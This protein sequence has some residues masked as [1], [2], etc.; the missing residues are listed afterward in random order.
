MGFWVFLV[1][2]FFKKSPEES[3]A[4][5][6]SQSVINSLKMGVA[7]VV[8]MAPIMFVSV[9]I[10]F[11]GMSF[12][13]ES[14]M[15][16]LFTVV[17]FVSSLMMIMLSASMTYNK[18]IV[19]NIKN[20]IAIVRCNFIR[21]L[22]IYLIVVA[23]SNV[24]SLSWMNSSVVVVAQPILSAVIGITNAVLMLTL[25]NQCIENTTKIEEII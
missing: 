14:L 4:I 5:K 6:I 3:I 15:R 21:L 16:P 12:G 11:I 13:L 7:L 19:V 1:M 22:V 17:M 25:F 10:S 20:S 8:F 23:L 24:L 18:G 9:V 2:Q